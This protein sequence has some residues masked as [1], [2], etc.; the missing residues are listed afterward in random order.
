VLRFQVDTIQVWSCEEWSARPL[1]SR[2]LEWLV[3]KM[4]RLEVAAGTVYFASLP[5]PGTK[6]G[7]SRVLRVHLQV[8]AIL[9]CQNHLYASEILKGELLYLTGSVFGTS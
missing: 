4:R 2:W 5:L 3:T 7:V 8:S 9:A 6:C 1:A